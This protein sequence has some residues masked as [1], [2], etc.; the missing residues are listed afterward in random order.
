MFQKLRRCYNKNLHIIHQIDYCLLLLAELKH[1]EASCVCIIPV[2]WI[3]KKTEVSTPSLACHWNE[4]G[5]LSPF[6]TSR[7]PRRP[8]HNSHEFSTFLHY[9]I[10]IA[11]SHIHSMQYVSVYE[12]VYS[13]D[14][15]TTRV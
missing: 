8:V 1:R 4:A 6:T 5:T 12:Q 13:R 10:Y 15:C 9:C 14:Y 7:L 3:M 2:G 11:T